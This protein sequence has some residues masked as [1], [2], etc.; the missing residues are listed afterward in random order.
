[1][2]MTNIFTYTKNVAKSIA[3]STVDVLSEQSKT[4]QSFVATNKEVL[5]EIYS[6]MRNMRTTYKRVEKA[7]KTSK[8]YEA[9]S[10]GMNAIFEDIKTGNFYNKER[11]D[12]FDTRALGSM[13]ADDFGDDDFG[14]W[15]DSG[16]DFGSW[17]DEEA[18]D[19]STVQIAKAVHTSSMDNAEAV[20]MTVAKVGHNIN[21]NNKTNTMILLNQQVKAN[22]IMEKGFT[23][24]FDR[25]G[26]VSKAS[27]EIAQTQAENSRKFFESTTATLQTQTAILQEMLEIQKRNAAITDAKEKEKTNSRTRYA[28]IVDSEGNVNI[29]EYGKNIYKNAMG[30]LPSQLTQM[31]TGSLVG[32]GNNLLTFVASPLK[33]IT[34][35]IANTLIPKV[36]NKSVEDFN[37]TLSGAFS[38]ILARFNKMANDESESQFKQY[39]GRIFGA[40]SE[41]VKNPNPSEYNK[42]P[43]PWNGI[44]QKS[45]TEVIPGYLRRIESLISGESERLY[46][47]STGKWTTG[48]ALKEEKDN[49]Y[50]NSYASAYSDVREQMTELLRS[51]AFFSDKD[52]KNVSKQMDN[53]L[54][55][56]VTQDYGNPRFNKK[57]R[58][59]YND[60]NV[61]NEEMM[62]MF[63]TAFNA[64]QRGVR[65]QL[66]KNS[67]E[68][69]DT[70]ANRLNNMIANNPEM[71]ELFNGSDIDR[72]FNWTRDGGKRTAAPGHLYNKTVDKIIDDKGHNMYYY[73]QHML[74]ELIKIRELDEQGG[75]KGRRR[76]RSSGGGNGG[77]GN[78]QPDPNIIIRSNPL[79]PDPDPHQQD[80]VRDFIRDDSD[81]RREREQARRELERR[82]NQIE[83][84]RRKGLTVYDSLDENSYALIRANIKGHGEDWYG[85]RNFDVYNR[86]RSM[87]EYYEQNQTWLNEEYNDARA[88]RRAEADAI[89][90]NAADG[91]SSRDKKLID[92]LLAA[93]TIGEKLKIV[94]SSMDDILEA[95]SKLLTNI[96]L[97]ADERLYNLVFG[98]EEAHY[99]N[100]KPVKGILD[101]MIYQVKETFSKVNDWIDEK[102]LT[103]L[104]D[105][106]G[107]SRPGDVI[108]K[109]GEV[110]GIDFR[111][112]GQAIHDWIFRENGFG[113]QF[114]TQLRQT[115]QDVGDFVRGDS[116]Q[117]S[118]RPSGPSAE[119]IAQAEKTKRA[120]ARHT[121]VNSFSEA[122]DILDAF[123]FGAKNN[124]S[125]L[126]QIARIVKGTADVKNFSDL[127][128]DQVNT[129]LQDSNFRNRSDL[130]KL[131]KDVRSKGDLINKLTREENTRA[132]AE[133]LA[134][135]NERYHGD[136]EEAAKII[137]GDTD[138]GFISA[139]AD[140]T[141]DV[142]A[143]KK[144]QKRYTDQGLEFRN[145][146]VNNP[147]GNEAI[148]ERI[149]KLASIDEKKEKDKHGVNVINKQLSKFSNI[150]N[151]D[152]D[153][154][155]ENINSASP[156]KFNADFESYLNLLTEKDRQY[157]DKKGVG[158][159]LFNKNDDG[160]FAINK[161]DF[162][163]FAKMINR[164]VTFLNNQSESSVKNRMV[165]LLNRM[166]KTGSTYGKIDELKDAGLKLTIDPTT[167]KITGIDNSV[168]ELQEIFN[169]EGL[170]LDQFATGARYVNKTGLTTIHEGEMVIPSE[171]N[172]F[173]PRRGK[174]SKASEI[175][176]E[177]R[178][179]NRFLNSIA[180]RIGSRATGDSGIGSVDNPTPLSGTRE[181]QI[182][183]EAA[184]EVQAQ[185]WSKDEYVKRIDEK[186]NLVYILKDTSTNKYIEVKISQETAV[187][188]GLSLNTD[189]QD[190]PS[191]KL[192][193]QSKASGRIREVKPGKNGFEY[194]LATAGEKLKSIAVSHGLGEEYEKAAGAINR[195]AAP[196]LAGAGV[197]GAIGLGAS[198][199]LGIAGGPIVGA[200]VGAVGNIAKNSET[201]SKFLFG[202]I[203]ETDE[204]GNTKRAG[205]LID[206]E[207]QEAFKKYAPSMGKMGLAGTVAG[208]VTPL[209][210]IAGAM[211]GAT[212]GFIK[213]NDDFAGVIFGPDGIWDEKDKEKFKKA[214]PRGGV[215]AGVGAL[216]GLLGGPFG[217]LGGAVVGAAT[218][219][220]STTDTFKNAVFGKEYDTGEKDEDGNAIMKRRG[221]LVG[222]L[223]NITLDPVINGVK[224]IKTEVTDFVRKDIISPLKSAVKPIGNMFKNM[225]DTIANS[226]S[227]AMNHFLEN[228]I[229]RPFQDWFHDR[230]LVKAGKVLKGAT[231]LPFKMIGNVVSSPFKLLG[232]VGDNIRATQIKKGTDFGST[233][234][235][236]M[237]FREENRH[238]FLGNIKLPFGLGKKFGIDDKLNAISG[239][240]GFSNDRTL[241][242]DKM[243]LDTDDINLNKLINSVS[244]I[245]YLRHGSQEAEFQAKKKIYETIDSQFDDI[246]NIRSK[247]VKLL[248]SGDPKDRTEALKLLRKKKSRSGEVLDNNAF[249]AL[250]QNLNDPISVFENA[251]A[252]TELGENGISEIEKQLADFGFKPGKNGKWNF[253][254][255]TKI[256]KSERAGRQK[257]GDWNIPEDEETQKLIMDENQKVTTITENTTQLVT[258]LEN[259]Y[260]FLHGDDKTDSSKLSDAVRTQKNEDG[261]TSV[262]DVLKNRR[263]DIDATLSEARG[264]IDQFDRQSDKARYKGSK[265]HQNKRNRYGLTL[266]DADIDYIDQHVN[267]NDSETNA[268]IKK[269]LSTHGNIDAETI[270][271]CLA[272]ESL[273]ERAKFCLNATGS[274]TLEQAKRI[275]RMPHKVWKNFKI[276]L[277]RSQA[278]AKRYPT[279]SVGQVLEDIWSE[280]TIKRLTKCTAANLTNALKEFIRGDYGQTTFGELLRRGVGRYNKHA[281]ADSVI[282]NPNDNPGPAPSLNPDPVP[283]M[284]HGGFN[285]YGN[286]TA[287]VSRD[288]LIIDPT[289]IPMYA[290]GRNAGL[291]ERY[292]DIDAAKLTRLDDM[293]YRGR[294]NANRKL[295]KYDR[296][297]LANN[298]FN[299][300]KL[301]A[302]IKDGETAEEERQKIREDQNK[303]LSDIRTQLS[304]NVTDDGDVVK[305]LI[306][307]QG[308][309]YVNKLDPKNKMGL[310]EGQTNN[311][312]HGLLEKISSGFNTVKYNLFEKPIDDEGHSIMGTVGSLFLKGL[313]T[314]GKF[315][316]VGT[317]ITALTKLLFPNIDVTDGSWAEKVINGAKTTVEKAGNWVTGTAIPALENWGAN[318]LYPFL[319]TQV[320]EAFGK[321]SQFVLNNAPAVGQFLGSSIAN[322]GHLAVS[323]AP[324][325]ISTL[326]N[327]VAEATGLNGGGDKSIFGNALASWFRAG[328]KGN[329]GSW[330]KNAKL[331]AKTL[332]GKIATAPFNIAT[333]AAGYGQDVVSRGSGLLRNKL[334]YKI[335][336]LKGAG[337]IK[338]SDDVIV[339]KLTESTIDSAITSTL[340]N[341]ASEG[342]EGAAEASVKSL[343]NQA[344]ETTLKNSGSSLTDVV[345][346]NAA[347]KVTSRGVVK[348]VSTAA[349][350]NNAK[351]F[352]KN[353]STELKPLL[354]GVVTDDMA[355]QICKKMCSSECVEKLSKKVVSEGA[356]AAARTAAGFASAGT[357]TII[358]AVADFLLPLM[359]KAEAQSILDISTEPTFGQKLV[360]AIANVISGVLP[361]PLPIIITPKLIIW[362]FAEV[363]F[364]DMD[365]FGI[366]EERAK[367]LAIVE[368]F[369][370]TYGTSYSVDDYNYAVN[371]EKSLWNRTVGNLLNQ[372][373]LGKTQE[374]LRA[375]VSA[376]LKDGQ[377]LDDVLSSWRNATVDDNGN[378]IVNNNN[379]NASGATT[380]VSN[381][382]GVEVAGQEEESTTTGLLTSINDILHSLFSW[383]T[384]S[385]TAE[386]YS[387]TGG[388]PSEFVQ[389]LMHDWGISYDEAAEIA[390]EQYGTLGEGSGRYSQKDK[391]INMRF[392]RPGDTVYQDINSSGCGPI[393]ATNLINRHIKSGM[394]LVDP[395]DAARYALANGY[396]EKNGGTNP[397]YFKNYFAKN[398]IDSVITSDRSKMRSAI[399]NGQQ[400]VLMGRDNSY[401]MGSTPYGP[402]PHYVVATGMNG[403]DIIIDNPEE[404]NEYTAYD[405]NDTIN[406]SSKAIITSNAK[407]GMGYVD[408]YTPTI[409]NLISQSKIPGHDPL[410]AENKLTIHNTPITTTPDAPISIAYDVGSDSLLHKSGA[411]KYT[412]KEAIADPLS[413]IILKKNK[414]NK[415]DDSISIDG[416]S[417]VD[418]YITQL[419]KWKKSSYS[420]LTNDTATALI[421]DLV[422]YYYNDADKIFEI[423]KNAPSK[424]AIYGL[425]YGSNKIGQTHVNLVE[426]LLTKHLGATVSD[427]DVNYGDLYNHLKFF[428][429]YL[430][431]INR[432]DALYATYKSILSKNSRLN[433]HG[434]LSFAPI[435][436]LQRLAISAE[437]ERIHPSIINDLN[438]DNPLMGFGKLH[439]NNLS[440]IFDAVQNYDNDDF[441]K[442]AASLLSNA[443][444][445]SSTPQEFEDII[446]SSKYSANAKT[447]V[448]NFADRAIDKDLFFRNIHALDYHLSDDVNVYKDAANKAAID[449]NTST[450]DSNNLPNSVSTDFMDELI[451]LT[452]ENHPDFYNGEVDRITPDMMASLFTKASNNAIAKYP[453][454][455]RTMGTYTNDVSDYLAKNGI[456]FN[457]HSALGIPTFADY[458][459]DH[460]NIARL[461]TKLAKGYDL[462]DLDPNTRHID[463]KTMTSVF[464]NWITDYCNAEDIL[465]YAINNPS[466]WKE[467]QSRL[468]QSTLGSSVSGG[469]RSSSNNHAG[470][471]RL[472][473]SEGDDYKGAADFYR[474]LFLSI[475]PDNTPGLGQNPYSSNSSDEI[476]S[477]L[478]NS[479]IITPDDYI[480]LS[481]IWSTLS[482]I[483]L[484]ADYSVGGTTYKAGTPLGSLIGSTIKSGP[485]VDFYRLLGDVHREFNKSDNAFVGVDSVIDY[486]HL[487]HVTPDPIWLSMTK[488]GEHDKS[489]EDPII[490]LDSKVIT[491]TGAESNVYSILNDLLSTIERGEFG[492][493]GDTAYIPFSY[494]TVANKINSLT[495]KSTSWKLNTNTAATGVAS[496]DAAL[497]NAN[498]FVAADPKSGVAWQAKE[499]AAKSIN[500][501][502]SS[503]KK[504]F[505]DYTDE[506]LA[507]LGL[508]KT[509]NWP[510]S[511]SGGSSDIAQVGDLGSDEHGKALDRRTGGATEFSNTAFEDLRVFSPLTTAQ[512]NAIISNRYNANGTPKANRVLDGKGS[513][514]FRLANSY[515]VNPRFVLAMMKWEWGMNNP[516]H[517]AKANYM[518]LMDPGKT[519]ETGMHDF[520]TNGSYTVEGVKLSACSSAKDVDTALENVFKY[521]SKVSFEKRKQYTVF[522][523]NYRNGYSY[524]G[525]DPTWVSRIIGTME[526]MPANT[527][528]YYIPATDAE[529]RFYQKLE[530]TIYNYDSMPEEGS[531]E[532]PTDIGQ[533]IRDLIEGIFGDGI[534]DFFNGQS[535]VDADTDMGGDLGSLNTFLRGRRF[536]SAYDWF[537]NSFIGRNG[538]EAYLTTD[539]PSSHGYDFGPRDM[540][541]ADG[542]KVDLH[543]GI[544]VHSSAGDQTMIKSPVGG[545]VLS[546]DTGHRNYKDD[547]NDKGYGNRVLVLDDNP[548]DPHIHLFAHLRKIADGIQS[549]AAIN[550]AD[551]IGYMGNTGW[552]TG[553]HL[554]YGTAVPM[555]D[556]GVNWYKYYGPDRSSGTANNGLT[557]E[558][559]T[560]SDDYSND[561]GWVDP[562]NYIAKYMNDVVDIPEETSG[563]S[564]IVEYSND[565]GDAYV[566]TDPT[567]MK[568]YQA[569]YY[570]AKSINSDLHS[571][572]R[573][574]DSITDEMLK[575]N[576][577]KKTSNWPSFTTGQGSGRT[578]LADK[579]I[580]DS[581]NKS[582]LGKG[583]SDKHQNDRMSMSAS[584]KN[585]VKNAVSAAKG[586]GGVIEPVHSRQEAKDTSDQTKLLA[587]INSILGTIHNDNMKLNQFLVAFLKAVQ[588]GDI[589]TDSSAF[590]DIL[591]VLSTS[592]GQPD[593]S[594]TGSSEMLI[595]TMLSM[596]RQ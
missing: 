273:L 272:D 32:D 568:N 351:A 133:I 294:T 397:R 460:Q 448:T 509:I 226:V 109:I 592:S 49:V 270:V 437:M 436:P 77:G 354:K 69:R 44:A 105:K 455:F 553:T 495:P 268:S 216:T 542:N 516:A 66:A 242:A 193:D 593:T 160:E 48:K 363:V 442:A 238:R 18:T 127:T 165:T 267:I 406:K 488:P 81:R 58:E 229:G 188:E 594:S 367:S 274:I 210:P 118:S 162:T 175:A 4:T 170:V 278:M 68:A 223:K 122:T 203:V 384:G 453:H 389:E 596:A 144:L 489:M 90:E 559:N 208:L 498:L 327:S 271:Y 589:K 220:L 157:L 447:L 70:I 386:D 124:E 37:T 373:A 55:T 159:G 39:L 264:S 304:Y 94:T 461:L 399:K 550:R 465:P 587:S 282:I 78:P 260:N 286:E 456:I 19:K 533:A 492:A 527:N 98:D 284:A 21:A 247:V 116:D 183:S 287:V 198:A 469:F 6:S 96:M 121:R 136:L 92:R 125:D 34:D 266:G 416:E 279:G 129:I 364:K 479:H 164:R 41:N 339:K 167:G 27:A 174:V 65:S 168:R 412:T 564:N 504:S 288:E 484:A 508:V 161:D 14:S 71:L 313:K 382:G 135:Y 130:K 570:A 379:I 300:R 560:S 571:G 299:Y 546:V 199:L 586:K 502:L 25:I 43:T 528:V 595:N 219:L 51:S 565:V 531:Y 80:D 50:K 9:V 380:T 573:S 56:I 253:G 145:V 252:A 544:D 359:D 535:K 128:D 29:R 83:N 31:L 64:T 580:T 28:D 248:T 308:E 562:N 477:Y 424:S 265:A 113:S 334:P 417:W 311:K 350:S 211:I 141:I 214:L 171:L 497:T 102:I 491:S 537:D 357:L 15:D 93:E 291:L 347:K 512:I 466:I 139:I 375:E 91:R 143:L 393:A 26:E 423:Y 369:N 576:G 179:K 194:T 243:L 250:I 421:R 79:P 517:I 61:E 233:A 221:G 358:F 63:I 341:T 572:E 481:R 519:G 575:M 324:T 230:V 478:Y 485:L 441:S 52:W 177:N 348:K 227:N 298:I 402:N 296:S 38:G 306:N 530:G 321:V 342:I 123:G 192:I 277:G 12:R 407:Y 205:G 545:T 154:V 372:T 74:T 500:G 475:H 480:Y 582:S 86:S 554:H 312:I 446:N 110:F 142:K 132:T 490:T 317:A 569:S 443:L 518:S 349:L 172:P 526:S 119:E 410:S 1:M 181:G 117:R 82:N 251:H 507:K 431:F 591:K 191:S 3:Y 463:S 403:S 60:Y 184:D 228:K 561:G 361:F 309:V 398:G 538:E 419:N 408:D 450:H 76:G 493:E 156:E 356:E 427:S 377:S 383:F 365:F 302:G 153:K 400:V 73:L 62:R 234:A 472:Y 209:G 470:S 47:W 336:K 515:G 10:E 523:L 390:K 95:P 494:D 513:V 558:A 457:P 415:P 444:A 59:R 368:A 245:E 152:I 468:S 581:L 346:G 555:S 566:T 344:I 149:E 114:T 107:I 371:D 335:A 556:G 540:S 131:L 134:K 215:G 222:L 262:P 151:I 53:F 189:V 303:I 240:I 104:K 422:N 217:L 310:R 459:P 522:S 23:S 140:G 8:L 137:F 2:A 316:G 67:F 521:F 405:A 536:N 579:L 295:S 326:Y 259:I 392:N 352:F 255:I 289:E 511:A 232:W 331:P 106:F 120:S 182:I 435:D 340:K 45:L 396:K 319:T 322:M 307:D 126:V 57:S 20:S 87:R 111:A 297:V 246:H 54:K 506:S 381:T 5:G 524:C 35:T 487:L 292:S 195:Y 24:I 163:K 440:N 108:Q 101:E 150:A 99:I 577:L 42:G 261:S 155:L 17:D 276:L 206:S 147:N 88:R 362:F 541:D 585:M 520:V 395:Q 314:V 428:Q 330:L 429:S 244:Q 318:T 462:S 212:V 482:Q 385:D 173:N 201:V 33:V 257:S 218:G 388:K 476:A 474:N 325:L 11:I 187:K 202:D 236:R 438:T 432:T 329:N 366:N 529:L 583:G 213:K 178:V 433:V 146:D 333:T 190:F 486:D 237:A 430:D 115:A 290:R 320:P 404:F 97:K 225:F 503:G 7:V 588:N 13:G 387:S 376:N 454:I 510:G 355:E 112:T 305:R 176:N 451:N 185:S 483:P 401:G 434:G 275:D 534:I 30:L 254:Q 394:G 16:D 285:R 283:A 103:P 169:R 186:G 353:V 224:F 256:L 158:F 148:L 36:V 505:N 180:R 166:G 200:L 496:Y 323:A 281:T 370:A 501:Y 75:R 391:S 467:E 563:Y 72:G 473:L 525:G 338:T 539:S 567:T 549:G 85:T 22:S 547:P 413:N 409:N 464:G 426:Q 235:E 458:T 258:V 196:T 532:E 345:V 328:L 204:N 452:K 197:G 557:W 578:S 263:G 46:S 249:E 418:Q 499:A 337:L 207:I 425:T 89:A 280:N 138:Q 411:I 315:V 84:A 241:A 449:N 231:T 439:M 40:K 574:F 414:L 543:K 552:S 378:V 551:N 360:A 269:L 445:L 471:L 100:G 343:T 293:L 548:T 374:E 590:S 420:G 301:E 514:I 332:F 584:S 239:A